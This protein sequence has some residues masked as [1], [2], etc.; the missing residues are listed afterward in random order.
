MISSLPQPGQ[1]LDLQYVSELAQSV[2]DLNSSIAS[3][4][5]SKTY[6]KN[7]DGVPKIDKTANFSFYAVFEPVV[8][9]QTI[10]PGDVMKFNHTFKSSFTTQPVV[11]VSPV[12]HGG[13]ETGQDVSVVITHV[14]QGSVRGWIKFNNTKKGDASLGLNIIAIGYQGSTS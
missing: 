4:A 12:N 9:N 5:Y 10:S 8:N 13:T 2:I 1:P 14:D 3:N 11:T 6:F 7:Q